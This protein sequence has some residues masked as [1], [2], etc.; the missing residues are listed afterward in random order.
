[1]IRKFITPTKSDFNLVLEFPDD[2]LGQELELIIFKKQE[3]LVAEK[4]PN[5]I[6]LSDKYKGVFFK[7][8][9]KSFNNHSQ[10]MRKKW[11]NI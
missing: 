3:G 2:Y 11:D 5:L 10:E 8:D 4:K 6:K 1:M 9:A 7:E